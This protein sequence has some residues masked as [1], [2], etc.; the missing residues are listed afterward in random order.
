MWLASSLSTCRGKLRGAGYPTL[1]SESSED[2]DLAPVGR[3]TC[4]R[5]RR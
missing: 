1:V 5:T 2:E 4:H 3:L